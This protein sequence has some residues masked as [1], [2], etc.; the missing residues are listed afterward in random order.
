MSDLASSDVFI[1][2]PRRVETH[3]VCGADAGAV[4]RRAA[5][6][7]TR[8]RVVFVLAER[9]GAERRAQ[10]RALCGLPRDFSHSRTRLIAFLHAP[11]RI[12]A[13]AFSHS[14]TAPLSRILARTFSHSRTRLLAFSHSATFSHSCTH[15]LAFP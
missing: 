1:A 8:V 6:G 7:Y 2:V 14:R 3:V 10:R 4:P 12:P 9:S 13:R 15:L 5:C 11:S